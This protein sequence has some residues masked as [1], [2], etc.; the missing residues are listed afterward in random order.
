MCVSTEFIWII[1]IIYLMNKFFNKGNIITLEP[2]VSDEIYEQKVVV[3]NTYCT[4][5][6]TTLIGY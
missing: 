5:L 3:Q 4:L 6:R 1:L 2:I